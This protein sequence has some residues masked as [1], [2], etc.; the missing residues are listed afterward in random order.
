MSPELTAPKCARCGHL[1]SAVV[2]Y[3]GNYEFCAECPVPRRSN[4]D[5]EFDHTFIPPVK[6]E[7]TP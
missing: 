1:F 5:P 2:G 6:K 3:G 4:S 7:R